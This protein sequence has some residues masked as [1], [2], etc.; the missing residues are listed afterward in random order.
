MEALAF[1]LGL[2]LPRSAITLRTDSFFAEV[3]IYNEEHETF[4]SILGPAAQRV[5]PTFGLQL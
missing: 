4:R 5:N 3:N 2:S 1:V